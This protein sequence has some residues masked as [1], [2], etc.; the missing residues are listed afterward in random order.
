LK[1]FGAQFKYLLSESAY[2]G[3]EKQIK[4]RDTWRTMQRAGLDITDTV[5]GIGELTA[6]E[7]GFMSSLVERIPVVGDIV[8]ASNRVHTGFLNKL[9]ADTFDAMLKEVGPAASEKQLKDIANWV[10]TA[11]GRGKFEN[12]FSKARKLDSGDLGMAL[13]AA[14]FSPKLQASRMTTL[15]PFFY[16]KLDPVVRKRALKDMARTTGIAIMTLAMAK[17]AGADVE[18]NPTSSDWGSA[19]AGTTRFKVFGGREQYLRL[20]ARLFT[21]STKSPTTGKVTEFQRGGPTTLGTIGKFIKNKSAPELGFLLDLWGKEDFKGDAFNM[22]DAVKDRATFMF[23]NDWNDI[24]K[25]RGF[26]LGTL[27]S[28]PSFF[29]IGGGTFDAPDVQTKE[30]I[31]E[32]R[33]KALIKKAKKKSKK[34]LGSPT[35]TRSTSS[36]KK[37]KLGD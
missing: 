37:K 16:A 22:T 8:H 23:L 14:F 26:G 25:E 35:N 3:L 19:R 4:S 24:V 2:V 18:T 28:I 32:D 34:K 10:N 12:L 13:N 27:M 9:R 29:G 36:T 7:E 5:G 17:A 11:T 30:S 6:R 1:A 33:Q 20:F 15:N 21:Q 31:E